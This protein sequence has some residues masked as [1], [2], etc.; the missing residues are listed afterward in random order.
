MQGTRS[1]V[2]HMTNDLWLAVALF[3]WDISS[4]EDLSNIPGLTVYLDTEWKYLHL[5]PLYLD[6]IKK[7]EGYTSRTDKNVLRRRCGRL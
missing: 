6:F 1:G 3:K 4:D 5:N 2:K 7:E